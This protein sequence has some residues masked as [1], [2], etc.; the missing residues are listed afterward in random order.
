MPKV[1]AVIMAGERAPVLAGLARRCGQAALAARG[2][3]EETLSRRRCRRLAPLVTED[4][5]WS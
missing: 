1:Y 2:R 3:S 4:R 5:V